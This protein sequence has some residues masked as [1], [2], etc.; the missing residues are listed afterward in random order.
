MLLHSVI[1]AGTYLAAKQ[2]LGELSPFAVALFRFGLAGLFYATVLLVRRRGDSPAIPRRDLW[3]MAGLGLVA[4][5]LNQGFFLA[6]LSRSTSGHAALMYALTP[7]FVFLLARWRLG[8]PTT[9]LKVAGILTAFA[10]VVLVLVGRGV[11]APG[12]DAWS[13]L[14]GDLMLLVAVIAWAAFAVGGKVYAERY[15]V[16]TMTS[17]AICFGTLA[18][19]PLGLWMTD[20]GSYA[21][22]SATAWWSLAYLVAFTSIA[23]YLI[24]YWAMQRSD[25]SRVAVW[26][27]TQPVFTALLAWSLHGEPITGAFVAGGAMVVA[28]VVLTDYRPRR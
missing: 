6:G 28:G 10:G 26:S 18:Y 17:V 24:Y 25:A 15:G 8:E 12:A 21:H 4:V 1:S 7:I 9:R 20:F 27:N 13:G 5:P 23:A 19:L 22:L 2:A 11:I 3:A 16:L 14:L